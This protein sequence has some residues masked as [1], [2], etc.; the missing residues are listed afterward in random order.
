MKKGPRPPEDGAMDSPVR[1]DSASD[2]RSRSITSRVFLAHLENH[3]VSYAV[4]ARAPIEEIEAIRK[5]MSWRFTWVSS[6]QNDFNG[7]S[8]LTARTTRS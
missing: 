3:D 2:A 6:Y 4:V 1:R 7:D 8:H 5:R